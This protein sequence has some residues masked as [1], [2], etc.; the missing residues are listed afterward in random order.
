MIF[1]LYYDAIQQTIKHDKV[2]DKI[3]NIFLHIQQT[4]KHDKVS[5]KIINIFFT[6]TTYLLTT[7]SFGNLA[8]LHIQNILRLVDMYRLVF[9]M[10]LIELS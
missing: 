8:Y 9:F 1:F 2:P 7:V 5:D 6:H 10:I 3:I 4:I